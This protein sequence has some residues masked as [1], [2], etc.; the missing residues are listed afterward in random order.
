MAAKLAAEAAASNAADE[1]R[2]KVR[3]GKV[4]KAAAEKRAREE[5]EDPVL[6]QC[7]TKDLRRELREC[8]DQHGMLRPRG[9][10]HKQLLI[11]RKGFLALR[12][13]PGNVE[14]Q[15]ARVDQQSA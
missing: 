11:E 6:Q 14:Q 13:Y 7:S 1:L 5:P 8:F 9:Q 12:V 10:H 4:A 15:N 3:A 2:V